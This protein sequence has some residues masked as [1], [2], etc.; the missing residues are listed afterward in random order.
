MSDE[1]IHKPSASVYFN[2]KFIVIKTLSGYRS[3]AE[4]PDHEAIFLPKNPTSQDCGGAVL[5]ALKRSR[6]ISLEEIPTFFDR[7]AAAARYESWINEMV[8]R[9]AYK[10]RRSLFKN[11][12]NCGIKQ[13][14]NSIV[15]VPM[16][17]EKA[18]QWLGI[19]DEA[20]VTIASDAPA[21]E[22]GGAL[23]VA[24]GRCT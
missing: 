12:R 22:V 5:L 18:E 7:H 4:D 2:E 8:V 13:V 14:E 24:L 19:G 11:L 21:S 15:F 9:Y 17:H 10:D 1:V 16:D 20:N 3:Y 6:H 23:L